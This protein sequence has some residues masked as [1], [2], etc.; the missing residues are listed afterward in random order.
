M[1]I[2]PFHPTGYP[3]PGKTT[4]YDESEVIDLENVPVNGGVLLKT[5]VLS[6]D[7]YL[8]GRMNGGPGGFV[9]GQPLTNYGISVVL[10]SESP[11]FKIGEH[12]YWGGTKFQEYNVV[13]ETS[14]SRL[15]VLE[16]KE[17]LPWSA[18]LG[19][20][21]MPGQTAYCGWQE[22]AGA[23]LKKRQ[24]V[25]VTAGAG[26]VGATVIQLAKQDGHKV[27][28]S[29]GSQ[30]KVDYLKKIGVDVAINYKT[31]ITKDV[32]A[33]EGPIDF[34]W[35]N[36]GG[37]SLEAAF[38]NAASK[39]R[40]VTVGS[41]SSYN[42]EPYGVKNI[43]QMV[44]KEITFFGFQVFSWLEKYQEAFY[45][46]IPQQIAEGKLDAIEHRVRGLENAGQVILDQQKGTYL[47]KPIIVV[48]LG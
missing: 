27:I 6:A 45:N 33:K 10:R 7:P 19:V 13:A 48:A 11:K 41:I 34:Y 18:Y 12:V 39:A 40:F 17:K 1:H 8:R 21:G 2:L 26:V 15:L 29:A 42:S 46:E 22:F 30:E 9:I 24:T 44:S 36:V 35:D 14:L 5:L 3:I 32:L 28:A 25:F 16:N 20:A 38:A 37:E 43:G 47:G 23:N 31:E 4:I